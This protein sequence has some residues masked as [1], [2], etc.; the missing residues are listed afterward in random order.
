MPGSGWLPVESTDIRLN[1][2]AG[3][4][5]VQRYVVANRGTRAVALYWYQTP[6]R[7]LTGEWE[8]KFFTF[9]DGLRDRRT[10][11]AIV[12]IFTAVRPNGGEAQEAANFAQAVYPLLRDLLPR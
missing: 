2:R 5:P 4:I 6:R 7:V 11:T 8:A 10:D 12:R 9:A 1:T 3:E